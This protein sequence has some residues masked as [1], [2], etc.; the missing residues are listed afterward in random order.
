MK[1][2]VYPCGVLY[3]NIQHCV[4]V[5][6]QGGTATARG[7]ITNQ[8]SRIS[9]GESECPVPWPFELDWRICG[10]GRHECE[11]CECP[12]IEIWE[13]KLLSTCYSNPA[14]QTNFRFCDTEWGGSV[15]VLTPCY[16]PPWQFMSKF[17]LQGG[18]EI[19]MKKL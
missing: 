3:R 2:I 11:T 19:G 6:A 9:S 15:L 4:E 1:T 12:R 10:P 7:W 13:Q 16:I 17:L 5:K 18:R 8:D 14:K